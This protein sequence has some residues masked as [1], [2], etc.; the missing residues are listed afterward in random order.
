MALGFLLQINMITNK[1]RNTSVQAYHSIEDLSHRQNEV[2]RALE[3]MQKASNL[4]ISNYLKMPINSITP[5]MNE[6]VQMGAVVESHRDIHPITGKR[7]I[8]W[9]IK[10]TDPVQEALL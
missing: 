1:V 7:V 4:D 6:L 8:Y 9:M 5:R 2:F 10:P 3:I